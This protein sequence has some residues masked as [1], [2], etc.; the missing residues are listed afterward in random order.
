MYYFLAPKFKLPVVTPVCYV[1]YFW[2]FLLFNLIYIYFDL[3]NGCKLSRE[4]EGD[5]LGEY[6]CERVMGHGSL[7][8][9]WSVK[10]ENKPASSC[11]CWRVSCPLPQFLLPLVFIPQ[12]KTT[13]LLTLTNCPTFPPISPPSLIFSLSNLILKFYSKVEFPQPTH[14]HI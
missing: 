11:L 4:S 1:L 9:V 14:V 8:M 12:T 2:C 10:R 7:V 13:P 3:G 6:V 5:W